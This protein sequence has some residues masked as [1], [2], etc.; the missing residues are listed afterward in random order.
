MVGPYI[1]MFDMTLKIRKKQ[2]KWLIK[3]VDANLCFHSADTNIMFWSEF[4]IAV[5]ESIRPEKIYKRLTF[6]KEKMVKCD[7]F[8]KG[9]MARWH[10]ENAIYWIKYYNPNLALDEV[11]MIKE[12]AV[13]KRAWG[14]FGTTFFNIKTDMAEGIANYQKGSTWPATQ[15]LH[16]AL[17][18]C[19]SLDDDSRVEKYLSITDLY[20]LKIMVKTGNKTK[21]RYFLAKKIIGG[22][23][24]DFDD[25]SGGSKPKYM[26]GSPHTIIRLRARLINISKTANKFDDWLSKT[27]TK[28]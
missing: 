11:Q 26:A 3:K 10:L 24:I 1:E 27:F 9:E 22:Y 23:Y 12:L 19:N 6:I 28:I 8:Y 14:T 18:G 25:W 5:R 13:D 15:K 7:N 21:E 2:Y 4:S 20:R 16:Q 17:S